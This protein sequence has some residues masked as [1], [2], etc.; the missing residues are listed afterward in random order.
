[1]LSNALEIYVNDPVLDW[2]Q[3]PV[4]N[5]RRSEEE[6]EEEGGGRVR[7]KEKEKEKEKEKGTGGSRAGKG[8]AKPTATL[9]PASGGIEASMEASEVENEVENEVEAEV[10][11]ASERL[12]QEQMRSLREDGSWEPRRRVQSSVRK[13]QGA[14]PALLLGEELALNG[15]VKAEKS[16]TALRAILQ[17]VCDD[18]GIGSDSSSGRKDS[19]D[20]EQ[21]GQLLTVEAQIDALIALATD[22][23][24]LVRQWVGLAPWI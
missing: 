4:N 16:L 7:G 1:V 23:N 11:D 22:P 15:R 8:K 21:Q 2:Y 24:V 13:L 5:R 18:I 12:W 10:E 3:R 9:E 17:E 19:K 20:D 14:H 6:E